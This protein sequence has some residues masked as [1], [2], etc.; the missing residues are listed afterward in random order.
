MK[1][2]SQ[3]I[4]PSIIEKYLTY[5]FWSS[6]F[7]F[8]FNQYVIGQNIN[9]QI[10]LISLVVMNYI[11]YYHG[12]GKPE[13]I[14]KN[15]FMPAYFLS[16][17]LC[18]IGAGFLKD[19]MG[20][21]YLSLIPCAAGTY[22]FLL[23]NMHSEV[24]HLYK[25]INLFFI[26]AFS[27]LLLSLF[28]KQ[29]LLSWS[30]LAC[31]SVFIL[32]TAGVVFHGVKLTYREHKHHLKRILQKNKSYR[33]IESL[34][35]KQRYFFHDLINITHGINLFLNHSIKNGQEL[36]LSE[37]E[38]IKNEIRMLESMIQ[39]HF[40]YK[41]KN[42][43]NLEQIV[44]FED[45]KG[46]LFHMVR[47]YLPSA[48]VE[49]H[50]IFSGFLSADASKYQKEKSLIHLP[51]FTRIIGNLVKNMAEVKT[52]QAEFI[53]D[54]T[55]SG[56]TIKAKNKIYKLKDERQNLAEKM[57]DLILKD[58]NIINGP[59][60]GLGI[61]STQ[62]QVKSL[63]GEMNIKI[64]NGYWITEIF[65]PRITNFENSTKLAA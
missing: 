44:S 61:L 8:S 59:N 5:S 30:E 57:R 51:S 27:Y 15:Q 23:R 33:H 25:G 56:F 20:P 26:G 14:F 45:A 2:K 4:S 17:T 12:A 16:Q 43:L 11:F 36:S 41:H 19:S 7:L 10:F 29:S 22:Y 55:D 53:F 50:F 35:S 1:K 58:Q 21:I 47:S 31:L 40:E 3:S 52:S 60:E 46:S 64:D 49:C 62:S 63:G 38:S 32:W 65:L 6:L 13:I 54:Y 9:E 42:L 28:F 18:L 34:E 24:E 39:D 48:V 37:T